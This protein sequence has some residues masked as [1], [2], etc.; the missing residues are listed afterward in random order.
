M[1]QKGLDIFFRKPQTP[2]KARKIKTF[3]RNTM[4]INFR[5]AKERNE[6]IL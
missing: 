5:L 3:D 6:E 2:K 1:K 4:A